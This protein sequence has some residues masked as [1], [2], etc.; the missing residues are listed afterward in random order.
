MK[1]LKT[2][3]DKIG[4]VYETFEAAYDMSKKAREESKR[5]IRY[6][7]GDS[8]TEKQ[9]RN[10]RLAQLPKL[11]INICK[12]KVDLLTGIE[13]ETR[14][15]TRAYPIEQGDALVSQGVDAAMEYIRNRND[16][17]A[18]SSR[19]F[20]DNTI[21]GMGNYCVEADLADDMT[22]DV[23][24]ARE[25]NGSIIWDPRSINVDPNVDA[26][27]VFRQKWMSPEKVKSV[28]NLKD[29]A[30]LDLADRGDLP[31]TSFEDG[32]KY[33]NA[34]DRNISLYSDKARKLVRVIEMWYKKYKEVAYMIDGRGNVIKS[35][36]PIKQAK[37][38]Y[39]KYGAD[40]DE[41][42]V[43]R[44]H[45]IW[46]LTVSGY[47]KLEDKKSPYE[48]NKF[49]FVPSYGYVE[50]DGD[51]IRR[52]G[53]IKNLFDLQDE[54]N[55][56]HTMVAQIL[57]TAPIGGGFFEKNSAD[58][59]KLNQI[60]G[61]NR[62]IGVNRIDNIKERGYGHLP[63]LNQIASLEE[64]TEQDGKEVTGVNDPMLGI[65]TG[66][67][68]SGL[69]AQV[70]IRQGTRTVQELFDNHDKAKLLVMRLAFS[71]ARQYYDDRK[72]ARILGSM[73]GMMGEQ[74]AQ[75]VIRRMKT[76]N[77]MQYDLKLDKGENSVTQRNATFL[78]TIELAQLVPEYRSVL[79]P[80]IVQLTDHPDK[81]E[82]LQAI[83]VQSQILNTE[84]AIQVAGGGKA[85]APVQTGGGQN[86]RQEIA[87]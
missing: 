24:I 38:L 66:A 46:V 64:I 33:Q 67:K 52:F 36:L 62:W 73:S 83:G 60:G 61:A 69:A 81:D 57:K 40:G 4:Y 27:Y 44:Q 79:L 37:K 71:V 18:V 41:L 11:E 16:A 26:E 65:P 28:Y 10:L 7:A 21:T 80:F 86:V 23:S 53:V 82:I 87:E 78:K 39:E 15:G 59:N 1:D 47:E 74:K 9:K 32:D 45:E 22:V 63:V 51:E 56:R 6:Y 42:I 31:R 2:N 13:R 29:D 35:P 50:D 30:K 76:A 20:K 14:T 34:G 25:P 48:H 17:D 8:L 54:K 19:V 72:W 85:A 70:R 5:A 77:L 55:S 12:P 75:E 3:N 43:R 49:P 84:K 58:E 68:E